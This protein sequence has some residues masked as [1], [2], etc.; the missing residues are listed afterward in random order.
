[1]EL[2]G[3]G[4]SVPQQQRA[5]RLLEELAPCTGC[6]FAARCAAE[7]LACEAFAAYSGGLSEVR[8]SVAPRVPSRA[9]YDSILGQ[10]SSAAAIKPRRHSPAPPEGLFAAL[11]RDGTSRGDDAT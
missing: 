8:W 3:A 4:M 7:L 1:M 9:R 5:D 2:S 11:M 10:E 6:R